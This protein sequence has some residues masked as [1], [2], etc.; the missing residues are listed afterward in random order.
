MISLNISYKTYEKSEQIMVNN[1]INNTLV[2]NKNT[3]KI[4]IKNDSKLP[5]KPAKVNYQKEL[6]KIL[7]KVEEE[8]TCPSLL[9]HSC[10]GPCSSYVLEY[11]GQYFEITVFYYN[12]NIYPSEEYWYRV[13]EQK[14]IIDLTRT[15]Y[16]IHMI[17]GA[18][19]VDRFY[20]TIA[21]ME[22]LPEGGARCHRCY[23]LRMSEAA[24]LA[25]EEGFDYFTS[26]LSFFFLLLIVSFMEY[27]HPQ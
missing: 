9:L 27:S 21:G 7:K 1:N 11:L 12:P 15:K 23:E 14:K 20:E 26:S 8:G 4:N 3:E 16:P 25:K 6:E 13:D 10:C 17:E 18:Y 22:G 2:N 19:E 5:V 24:K